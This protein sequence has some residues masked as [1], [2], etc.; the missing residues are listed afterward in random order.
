[1]SDLDDISHY[2]ELDAR[3][4]KAARSLRILTLMSWPASSQQPFLDSWR[5]GKPALPVI[6]YPKHDFADVRREL[7]A[8]AETADPTHPIGQYLCESARSWS[9]AGRMLEVLGTNEVAKN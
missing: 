3:M 5:A 2:A 4:L 8:V 6:E 7:D 1:M 9:T